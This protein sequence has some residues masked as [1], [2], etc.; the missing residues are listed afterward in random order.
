LCSRLKKNEEAEQK[1]AEIMQQ[2]GNEIEEK[3]DFMRDYI[4]TL[5]KN[6]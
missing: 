1:A 3:K 2:K 6:K 4:A 5:S